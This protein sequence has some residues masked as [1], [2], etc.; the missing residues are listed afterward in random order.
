MAAAIVKFDALP[1]TVRTPAQDHHFGAVRGAGLAFDFA[2]GRGLVGGVHI[3][4]LSLKF[5]R[6]GVD[7][8][9]YSLYA[10]IQTGAPYV[11]FFAAS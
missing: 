6:T 10:Q 8:F 3:W 5:C 11:V 2:E 4:G 7:T 9:E 1:N